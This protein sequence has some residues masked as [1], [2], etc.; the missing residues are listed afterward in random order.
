M[1]TCARVRVCVC[2]PP[3]SNLSHANDQ[4]TAAA[5]L[6]ASL[7]KEVCVNVCVCVCVSLYYGGGADFIP[8]PKV[9]VLYIVYI[10]IERE[11]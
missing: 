7:A 8:P 11:R 10:Y 5:G 4:L 3:H 1:F 6:S 9:Y 2:V